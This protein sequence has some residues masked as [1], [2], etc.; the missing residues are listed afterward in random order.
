MKA[1]YLAHMGDDLMVANAARVSFGKW[2]DALDEKDERL[3]RYLAKH[4]HWTP[5][6]HPQIQM[7]ITAPMFVARQWFRSTVG[8]ARNEVSRRYVDDAP[9]FFKP[10]AWRKKPDGSIKQGS[11]DELDYCAQGMASRWYR[12]AIDSAYENY[13]AML[14]LG[15]APEQAR[16]ILPQCT[17][18]Q[19]IETG[20]L[21][22]YA[23]ICK[24]RLDS[25]AQVE[26]Q[27]LA[28]QVADI[29]APL[30]PVSWSSVNIKKVPEDIE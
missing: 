13:F 27:S 30:Y 12:E 19:W 5:F 2:K 3:I 17:E 23:R 14:E 4:E 6:A 16:M 8:V 10:D 26:I 29:V 28:K 25:H 11:G 1:E 15:A 18:T 9:D 22:Y 20:S 24:Q 7:R 21:A